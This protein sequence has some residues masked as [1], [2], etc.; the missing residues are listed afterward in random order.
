MGTSLPQVCDST[1][2]DFLVL[3]RSRALKKTLSL[4]HS[5]AVMSLDVT[6]YI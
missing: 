3:G 6:M 4:L 1:D 5:F 2:A